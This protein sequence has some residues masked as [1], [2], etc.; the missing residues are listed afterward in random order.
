MITRKGDTMVKKPFSHYT[1]VM[2]QPQSVN[3]V[4][5]MTQKTGQVGTSGAILKNPLNP[6]LD[7][8]KHT[9]V[10]PLMEEGRYGK[11]DVYRQQME[12]SEEQPPGSMILGTSEQAEGMGVAA[13]GT[14]LAPLT[15]TQTAQPTRISPET[16]IGGGFSE[17]TAPEWGTTEY[18]QAMYNQ[19]R[20]QMSGQSKADIDY[21]R[22]QLGGRGFRAGESGIANKAIMNLRRMGSERLGAASRDIALQGMGARHG[23]QMDMMNMLMRMYGMQEGAQQNAFAPYWEN[24]LQGGAQSVGV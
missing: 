8:L 15:G 21:A 18:Q 4:Q 19:A 17:D 22:T 12:R 9:G 2:N 11:Q 16:T 20:E 1:G 7:G 24:E 6:A 5:N 3:G 14:E 10:D 13:P 23:Q